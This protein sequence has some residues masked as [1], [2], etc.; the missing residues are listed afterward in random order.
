MSKTSL[1]VEILGSVTALIVAITALLGALAGLIEV[2]KKLR[3][4]YAERDIMIK[5]ISL[6]L[7]YIVLVLVLISGIIF[8]GRSITQPL[9]LSLT[10]AAWNA[11]N[12]KDYKNAIEMA[13]ECIFNFGP[14]AKRIQ[15]ELESQN[16]PEPPE[17]KV[18]A[19]KKEEILNKGILNDVGTCWY[20]KGISLERKG[21]IKEAIRSYQEAE[22]LPHARTYDP[23]WD[24]FW[25]PAKSARDRRL[26]LESR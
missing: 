20:I 21:D 17:G 2:I 26:N 22:S 7:L 23:S 15:R 4:I 14:T 9:N 5:K 11:Y 10:T 13:D 16:S 25:S 6:K 8:V 18:S 1:I 19:S 3:K 12:K 24:G